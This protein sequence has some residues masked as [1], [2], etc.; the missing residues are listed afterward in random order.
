M[1]FERPIPHPLNTRCVSLFAPTASGLYG[2]STQNEWLY[3]GESDN[4]RTALLVFLE[5]QEAKGKP[6]DSMLRQGFVFELCPRGMR[7]GR[8]DQ[9]VREYEPKRNRGLF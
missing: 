5:D 9:L 8:Q 3:I 1:P 2:I 7:P 6:V 4:I